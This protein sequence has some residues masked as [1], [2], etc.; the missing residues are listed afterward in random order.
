MPGTDALEVGVFEEPRL[1][2]QTLALLVEAHADDRVLVVDA[3]PVDELKV[4]LVSSE[5]YGV[6]V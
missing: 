2:P 1:H 5:E 4:V 6:G 3:L